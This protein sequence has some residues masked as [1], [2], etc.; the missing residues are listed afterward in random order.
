MGQEIATT[1]PPRQR[2]RQR[3]PAAAP[4]PA[5]F[6]VRSPGYIAEGKSLCLTLTEPERGEECPIT[7]DPI[8]EYRLPFYLPEPCT[9]LLSRPKLTKA[10][11][12]CGHGFNALALVYHFTKNSMTCPICRAG[13]DKVQ[14]GE[15]SVPPHLRRAFSQHLERVRAEETREQIAADAI[16]ATRALEREVWSMGLMSGA[17]LPVTR[18]ML[19]LHAFHSLDDGSTAGWAQELPLTSSLIPGGL[20]FVS[21]GYSLRQANLNLRLLLSRP[22]AFEIAVGLQNMAHGYWPLFRTARFPAEGP[23]RRI[24][25]ASGRGPAEAMAVEVETGPSV[26]GCPVLTRLC[27][28]VPLDAFSNMLIA[29][30]HAGGGEVAAV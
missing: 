27:W 4:E 5:R 9:L 14:M 1:D 2:K 25:F 21:Y 18:V 19:T 24:V 6:V 20:A 16:A 23:G 26:D 3:K 12:P 30:A 22:T 8:A 29:M 10:T 17:S 7:M 11:L 28:G 15:Q 13:H